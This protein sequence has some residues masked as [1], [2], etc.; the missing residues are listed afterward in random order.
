[1]KSMGWTTKETMRSMDN[2]NK[3]QSQQ[4]SLEKLPPA[5]NREYSPN[6]YEQS[7]KRKCGNTISN[8][9]CCDKCSCQCIRQIESTIMRTPPMPS[10]MPPQQV[11]NDS[12]NFRYIFLV[13][14]A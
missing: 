2:S 1:M 9:R 4:Y 14:P 11:Q 3:K 7:Q 10:I 13:N 12:N 8:I 6:K 5:D